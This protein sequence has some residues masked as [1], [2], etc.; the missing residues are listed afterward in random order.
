MSENITVRSIVGRFL[1]HSRVYRFGRPGHGAVYYMGSADM[2][3]RNLG[4]RVETL[5]PVTNPQ[6]QERLEEILDVL[7][8]DDVLAWELDATGEWRKVPTT[9]GVDSHETLGRLALER[10]EKAGA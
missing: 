2:M 3:Q 1:E 8:A 10:R 9:V 6:M 7:R 5:V 4:G